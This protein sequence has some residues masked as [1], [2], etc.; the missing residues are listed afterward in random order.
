MSHGA[1]ALS[2]GTVRV[3]TLVIAPEPRYRDVSGA[4]IFQ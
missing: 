4:M 2:P 1:Q 3:Q